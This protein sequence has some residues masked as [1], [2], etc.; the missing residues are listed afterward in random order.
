MKDFKK[1]LADLGIKQEDFAK[2]VGITYSSFRTMTTKKKLNESS[3][4]WVKAFAFGF[5]I[6]QQSGLYP[7]QNINP[8]QG[9]LSNQENSPNQDNY[10]K[11]EIW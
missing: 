7:N 8:N 3:P 2:E 6:G 10:S 1:M 9:L 11:G 4:S 5:K